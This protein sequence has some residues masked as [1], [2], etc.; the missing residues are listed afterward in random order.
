MSNNTGMAAIMDISIDQRGFT[1][2]E[3]MIV[4]AIIG[5][6]VSIAIPI[7]QQLTMKAATNSCL[8]EAKS[9]ANLV[10]IKLNEPDAEVVVLMPIPRA[11]VSITDATG[12]SSKNQQKIVAIAKS[13]SNARIECDIPNGSPCKIVP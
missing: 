7:Y 2:L 4:T 10:Y 1:L 5:V 8:Y 6:I 12:W 9:Y 13:P 3:L 11:C